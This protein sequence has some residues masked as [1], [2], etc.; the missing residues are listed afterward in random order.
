MANSISPSTHILELF[1]IKQVLRNLLPKLEAI[2]KTTK[3]LKITVMP[4]FFVDRIIE[5]TDY[6]SFV[7]ETR[8]KIKAGGGSLRG[9]SSIDIK[10]GNAVNVAYCLAKLGLCI[11]LYTIADE[12]GDSILNSV[13]APFDNKVNLY[14]KRGKHGLSTVFEF[15][16]PQNIHSSA[17]VMV[18]DVGD[19]DNF[20]PEI[21]ESDIHNLPLGSSDAVIITNWA[22]NLRG[23]DLL[24]TVFANSSHSIHFLD[25]AD[26][27]KRCFEFINMVKI[28]SK[29]IDILSINENEFNQVIEALQSIFDKKIINKDYNNN[30]INSKSIDK[31]STKSQDNAFVNLHIFDGDSYPKNIGIMC[32]SLK[33][34]SR[35]FNLTMCLHTT[36]GSFMCTPESD[37]GTVINDNNSESGS[38]RSKNSQKDVTRNVLFVAS[39]IPSRINIVSGAGD[40]WDAGFMFGQLVGFEDKEKLCFAN[41]LAS[42]HVENLFNDDPSLTE[43]IDYIRSI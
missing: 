23:T 5:V 28:N 21:F 14:I 3:H 9:Y 32:E 29:S 38:R 25:P 4:D 12:V 10:G 8:K 16:D 6:A 7:S 27:E 31:E 1:E 13:F 41:L 42:L 2:E 39:I 15:S 19:N 33:T 34:L 37:D 17:N 26:I 35:Y 36:K 11:D 22:S 43:V 18:S 30:N 24:Q 40:S 20:G